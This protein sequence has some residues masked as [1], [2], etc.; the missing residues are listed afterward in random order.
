MEQGECEREEQPCSTHVYQMAGCSLY[1]YRRIKEGGYHSLIP[2]TSWRG[3]PSPSWRGLPCASRRGVYYP[4]KQATQAWWVVLPIPCGCHHAGLSRR[5]AHG[6]YPGLFRFLLAETFSI[7][8]KL[9][10]CNS[11]M[12]PTIL[13]LNKMMILKRVTPQVR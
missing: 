10:R 2:C 13:V 1:I 3:L 8:P 12:L 6:A 5:A 4:L 11:H 9:F 7:F